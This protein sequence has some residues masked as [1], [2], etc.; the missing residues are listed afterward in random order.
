MTCFCVQSADI[1]G[2]QSNLEQNLCKAKDTKRLHKIWWVHQKRH[3]FFVATIWT[4]IHYMTTFSVGYM[5]HNRLLIIRATCTYTPS[6]LKSGGTIVAFTN[7]SLSVVH[8][9]IVRQLSTDLVTDVK[10]TVNKTSLTVCTCNKMCQCRGPSCYILIS[11]IRSKC[12][13][14]VGTIGVCLFVCCCHI[15]CGIF[16]IQSTNAS[17]FSRNYTMQLTSNKVCSPPQGCCSPTA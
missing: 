17:Q 15:D 8:M 4:G 2:L 11:A 16:L 5:Y 10:S 1:T 3:G 7:S 13:S 9:A 12:C 14:W 6:S